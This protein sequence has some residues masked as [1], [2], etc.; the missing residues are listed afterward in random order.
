[1]G[2]ADQDRVVAPDDCAVQRR[3]NALVGLGTG[4]DQAPD[5]QTGQDSFQAGVLEG[6]RETFG[7]DRLVIVRLEFGDDLPVIASRGQILVGV[8]DPDDRDLL[9]PRSLDE[10]A[11]FA[12]T[13]SRS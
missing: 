10:A 1:M 4:D 9:A 6:V 13:A 8:P 12:T 7:D 3:A 11:T 5:A 2:V